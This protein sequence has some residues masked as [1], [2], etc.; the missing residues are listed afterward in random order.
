M[1]MSAC[2]SWTVRPKT[3]MLLKA[4]A[5]MFFVMLAV[6][7]GA[8]QR[9]VKQRVAPVYPEVA[10]RLRVT[11]MVKLEVTVDAGGKVKDVKTISGNHMLSTAAEEAVSKWK[12]AAGPSESIEDLDINFELN[13]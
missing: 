12:F 9:A 1:K 13:Q 10:K 3:G 11:G 5:W 4:C 2:A 7:G 8:E 6:S